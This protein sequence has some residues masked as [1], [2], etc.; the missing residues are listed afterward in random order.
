MP[1]LS[2]G[3]LALQLAND[4]PDMRVLYTSGYAE[5]ITMR[6]GVRRGLPL[7]AKPFVAGDIVRRVR[8]TL[9]GP[10]LETLGEGASPTGR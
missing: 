7:L 4:R 6:S 1:G 3:D 8:E 5:D 2:G 10:L 9:D